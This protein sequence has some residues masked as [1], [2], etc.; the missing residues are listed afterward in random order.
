MVGATVS[1]TLEHTLCNALVDTGATRSCLSEEYYQQLLLPGLKPVHKL[2]IRTASGSSLCPTGTITCDFKLGKQPF[3]FEFIVCR[4]LSRPCILGLD[5][6]R[7]YKIGIGWSPNGKFQLDLHQQVL[8]K[9]IKVYMS[10][11]TLQTRQYI[12]IPSRSLM[13]L[14][15]KATIDKHMEGGLHKV[16]PNFLLS[17]DYPQLVL[18][19][20]VHNVEITKIECIPYVLLNLSEEAIFLRKGE[21]LRQLEKED[22]TIE[23]ITTETML[24]CKDMESENLNC[25][26]LKKMF[27]ASPVSDDTCKKV[28]LQDAKALNHHK[29]TIEEVTAEA[30][31]QCKDME[32]EKLNCGDMLKKTFIASPVNVATCKK[33]KQQNVEALSYCKISV[34]EIPTGTMLQSEGMEIKK[35]HCDILSEK[36]FIASPAEIDACRKVK[37][38]DVEVLNINENKY[39]ETMLQSE[40]MEN[41]KPHCD[42][43]S[44]KKFITSPADVDTHRKVKLQDAEVLDKYK[45]EFEKLCEEYNDIFS[46]DSSDI[47]KT[48]LITME[49]E[50]GDSPPVCQ[51]PY[52]LPLKHIDWVQK[53]LNTLEKAGVITRSVS[54]WASPIVI[55]PKRTAPGE[56][57]KKRLCV[58][59]RVINSLLPKVN[60]AHSKAKGLLTLVRLPKIDEI[61]AR[62]K[63]SK[64]YS[65]FD[66]QSGYHHMGLSTKARPKSAFITPTDKYEFTRCPFGLMQVPAY[67][68][69]LI[70]K[71]L[72]GLD[73]AFGYLDDI[74]IYSPDVPTHLVHMRQLFQRLKEADLK[75]NRE[76]C[77]FFKSH[78][79]YLGHLI[80]GEGIKPLPEKLESI[81]EMPPPTTPKEIKQYLGLL[82]YYRKFI[83]RFTDVARPLTKLTRLDQPF[84][85]S[86]KCQAS[87][88]LLKE[89]L[90]KEPILRF[91]DPNK[92]YTL[93]TDASKYAWSCVLTQQYTHNMDNRQIV[94]N[95]PITY[96]S[97]LFKGS[98]LN[99]AA[100]TKE[101]YAIYMSIKK[102]TYYLEDA[103]ITLRS[104]HLPLKRFLQRN[105]LNTKVN[106]WA[107]EISPFKITFE[108]I[109]GIKNT[110]VDTISRLIALDPDNQLV[111]E[112]EGFEYGYYAFDN[113]DP[114]KT[115]V[116]INE[117]TNKMGVETPVN[118][119]GEDITLPIEDNKLIELQK[120]DKFCKNILNILAS[121]KLQNKN[122]YY[123]KSGILK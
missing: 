19:P 50:T 34:E 118:L 5:F 4:G 33:V 94:V 65:G 71:V 107:V 73:F 123:I 69:R 91:P 53:E 58:D 98:Q 36:E 106:N 84:K 39:K 117:M 2:Q 88:E 17:D 29:I 115:Q 25:G 15:A 35:P 40:G 16:V 1:A 120:E 66:A 67:F 100:L 3:S 24:Q 99:W 23:E 22:I 46:K 27:I 26:D 30:M 68:Q 64:V 32:S 20:T 9:S 75:L 21:I 63:G 93:Y 79:Q 97:G 49:I 85:W 104:D 110:L 82:G 47:G 43:S 80:S 119:P 72:V 38:Q 56:P 103:E 86:D 57:P 8:V 76:K 37:L 42:M 89:A 6:L 116:E 90:I 55:V 96:V 81:K 41:E 108:Y 101:A 105:T 7:K 112:P 87:F 11:P 122:L 83:P 44:E 51:R 52:N 54:P 48:P 13:V 70:N 95:H 113:I 78:I 14:N 92:P 10:G 111:D 74:L 109:K 28:R 18:I 121:N 102:L 12:T 114:I 45:E 60:K 59:Y 77:N 61:Y 62:L 31:L